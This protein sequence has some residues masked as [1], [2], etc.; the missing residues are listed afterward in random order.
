MI[1]GCKVDSH[2][3]NR[4]KKKEEGECISEKYK[5]KRTS[6]KDRKKKSYNIISLWFYK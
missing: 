5:G 3:T 4:G 2:Y 1:V 6:E